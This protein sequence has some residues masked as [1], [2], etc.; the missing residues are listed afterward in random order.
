MFRK[1]VQIQFLPPSII[2]LNLIDLTI[3]FKR[4]DS[5]NSLSYHGESF[6]G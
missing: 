5:Q 4:Y 2:I 1:R 6:F 3:T